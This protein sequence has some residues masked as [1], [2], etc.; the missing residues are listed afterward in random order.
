LGDL[1]EIS[2]GELDRVSSGASSE[3]QGSAASIGRINGCKESVK[4]VP[5]GNLLMGGGSECRRVS[6]EWLNFLVRRHTMVLNYLVDVLSE[7]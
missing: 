2:W 5:G 6:R 4:L 1:E 3:G 7:G